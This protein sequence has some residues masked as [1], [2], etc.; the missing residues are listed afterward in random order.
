MFACSTG[1]KYVMGLHTC[2]SMVSFIV[3]SSLR[4]EWPLKLFRIACT[5]CIDKNSW[6]CILV[7]N[8]VLLDMIWYDMIWYDMIWYDMIWYDMIWY[9]MIWH[10][11]GIIILTMTCMLYCICV[12][13]FTQFAGMFDRIQST[14]KREGIE[15]VH[16]HGGMTRLQRYDDRCDI[17]CFR[18]LTHTGGT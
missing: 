18:L 13:V 6:H 3:T 2:T 11:T 8:Y 9:D 10:D 16:I 17:W 4:S 12:A 15:Y 1:S 5:R 7:R 14:L